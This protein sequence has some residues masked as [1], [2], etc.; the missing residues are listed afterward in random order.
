MLEN[1]ISALQLSA[2]LSFVLGAYEA[3]RKPREEQLEK[4]SNDAI[5]HI[6]V[7]RQR[8]G[9][10]VLR[11]VPEGVM[12]NRVKWHQMSTTDLNDYRRDVATRYY[13]TI[14]R[15]QRRDRERQCLLWLTGVASTIAL[16]VASANPELPIPAFIGFAITAVLIA[17]PVMCMFT[18][19]CEDIDLHREASPHNS[20]AAEK[21]SRSKKERSVPAPG[22]A[23]HVFNEI[24][25]RHRGSAPAEDVD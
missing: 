22:Q 3:H 15:Y 5:R 21:R 14:A 10:T 20:E 12:L 23:F 18:V 2:A 1:W 6:T 8:D 9:G 7:L 19:W 17:I 24:R 25:R 11:R 13:K 4:W 16:L